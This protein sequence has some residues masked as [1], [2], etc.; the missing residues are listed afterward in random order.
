MPQEG[1]CTTAGN[2]CVEMRR[3]KCVGAYTLRWKSARSR[4]TVWVEGFGKL[5]DEMEIWV[6]G[7]NGRPVRSAGLAAGSGQRLTQQAV[8]EWKKESGLAVLG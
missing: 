7:I 2:A 8:Q 3:G 6:A 1:T 4:R 5:P